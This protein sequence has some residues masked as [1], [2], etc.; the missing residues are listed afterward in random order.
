MLR[1]ALSWEQLLPE[2]RPKRKQIEW[3]LCSL[4][5]GKREQLAEASEPCDPPGSSCFRGPDTSILPEA[6]GE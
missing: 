1:H 6:V 5:G 3:R 2:P 4:K